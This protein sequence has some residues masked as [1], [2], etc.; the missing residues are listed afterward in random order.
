MPIMGNAVLV[1]ARRNNSK[2]ITYPRAVTIASIGTL[3]LSRARIERHKKR[4][5]IRCK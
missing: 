1:V 4:R 2:D 3:L 5:G